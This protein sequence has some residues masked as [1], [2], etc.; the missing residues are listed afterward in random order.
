MN[1]GFFITVDLVTLDTSSEETEKTSSDIMTSLLQSYNQATP[2]VSEQ[3]ISVD[4]EEQ[5]PMMDMLSMINK[6]SNTPGYFRQFSVL[7]R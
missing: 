3:D 4:T 2:V 6:F 5:V 1:T 7:F